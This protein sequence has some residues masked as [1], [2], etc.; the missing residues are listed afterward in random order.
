MTVMTGI[1]ERFKD[2]VN[3]LNKRMDLA[4]CRYSN[5]CKLLSRSDCFLID[6]GRC[7]KLTSMSPVGLLIVLYSL[8]AQTPKQ[9]GGN[10]VLY[11]VYC[12]SNKIAFHMC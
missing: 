2:K 3:K 12:S 10:Y 7:M 1:V 8:S 4:E 9:G 6:R 11:E 5:T